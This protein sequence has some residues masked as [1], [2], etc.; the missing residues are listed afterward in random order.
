[1]PQLKVSGLGIP[2]DPAVTLTPIPLKYTNRHRKKEARVPLSISIH[3]VLITGT[4]FSAHPI[5]SREH[6]F[7]SILIFISPLFGFEEQ[8]RIYPASISFS[9]SPA[10]SSMVT[11]P[12]SNL[13]L[14]AVHKPL[15]QE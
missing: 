14:Q 2:A 8:Q 9:L 6:P 13:P 3:C 15:W 11:F 1:M 4:F 7:Y 5:L 12:D 10:S